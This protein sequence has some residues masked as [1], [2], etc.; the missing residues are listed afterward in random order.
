[1]SRVRYSKASSGVRRSGSLTISTSGR[2]AAVEVDVG[3]GDGVGE[4]IVEALARVFFQ[5]QAGDADALR[6]LLPSASGTSMPAVLGDGLVELRDLVA[7]G[8]VGVEVVLAGEDAGLA[9]LAVD[10]L[11]GQHGELD[12]AA[13]EHGQRAGQAE[14]GGADVGV[15]LAAVAG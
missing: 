12:G 3:A 1:M 10:R 6:G 5:V 8:R 15:G 11:G 4:A 13:V 9:D 14:A 2:A 7:L